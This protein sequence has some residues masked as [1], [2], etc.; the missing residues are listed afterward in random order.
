MRKSA[1]TLA[2]DLPFDEPTGAEW[3]LRQLGAASREQ[4]WDEDLGL[5]GLAEFPEAI[6]LPPRLLKGLPRVN[7]PSHGADWPDAA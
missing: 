5:R 6:G 2:E 1:R 7:E 3:F 4:S